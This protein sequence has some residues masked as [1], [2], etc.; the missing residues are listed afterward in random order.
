MT[1][2][3]DW[4]CFLPPSSSSCRIFSGEQD[5]RVYHLARGLLDLRARTSYQ[6]RLAGVI[7]P[8]H[9]PPCPTFSPGTEPNHEKRVGA[10][11]HGWWGGVL[12]KKLG[13]RGRICMQQG[14]EV[15]KCGEKGN[16]DPPLDLVRFFFFFFAFVLCVRL[17]HHWQ[18]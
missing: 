8:L 15:R 10:C 17:G 6:F 1:I 11:N 3:S 12:G 4:S 16:K 2:A 13:G 7:E 14:M 18:S 5:L 9:L